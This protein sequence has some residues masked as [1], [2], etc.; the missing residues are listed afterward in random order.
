MAVNLAGFI[1]G[2]FIARENGVDEE[3]AATFGLVGALFPSPL[4]GAVVVQGLT[5]SS[6]S[7]AATE[8]ITVTVPSS[9]PAAA[10]VYLSGTLSVLGS[11]LPDWQADGMPMAQVDAFHW[12]AGLTGP[13]GANLEYKFTL[14][15]FLSVEK[16][17]DCGEISNRRLALPAV[18]SQEDHTDEVA[19]WNG[20]GICAFTPQSA[21]A[22]SAA[23]VLAAPAAAAPASATPVSD[24]SASAGP[25][26]P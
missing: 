2:T 1:A 6:N 13:G 23:P 10:K 20:F 18:G 7:Q 14:G 26:R 11:G 21:P 24:T 22:A 17:S 5:E 12:Q 9:T 25:R 16:G 19:N 8:I 3:E 4:L 15:D